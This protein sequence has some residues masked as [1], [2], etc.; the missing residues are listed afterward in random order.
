MGRGRKPAACCRKCGGTEWGI[1]KYGW[2]FCRPCQRANSKRVRAKRPASV[3]AAY[4]RAWRLKNRDKHRQ[5]QRE[6]M[7]R[8]RAAEKLEY[9]EPVQGGDV[10][11][12]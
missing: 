12:R 1:N 5:Y 3:K 11:T 8:R 9:T 4:M 2:R 10:P 7:A 6:Y